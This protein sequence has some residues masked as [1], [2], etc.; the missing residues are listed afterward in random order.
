MYDATKKNLEL[1]VSIVGNEQL[2]HSEIIT[3]VQEN[4]KINQASVH[5]WLMIAIQ[6]TYD[7]PMTEQVIIGLRT[8]T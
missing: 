1:L 8:G 2:T 5:R 7:L 4:Q 6:G 3:R